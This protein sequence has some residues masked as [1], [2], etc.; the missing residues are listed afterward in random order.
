MAMAASRMMTRMFSNCS[1]SRRHHGVS[2]ELVEAVLLETALR[3]VAAQ[4]ARGVRAK[5]GDDRLGRKRIRIGAGRRHRTGAV[6]LKRRRIGLYIHN[7]RAAE[8]SAEN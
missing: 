6:K 4:A 1:S 2:G 5:R 7:A 3:L 8:A